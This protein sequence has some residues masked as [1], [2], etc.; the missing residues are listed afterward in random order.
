ML[1][2]VKQEKLKTLLINLG[3]SDIARLSQAIELGRRGA[4]VDLPADEI[5]NLLRPA[6]GDVKTPHLPTISRVLCEPFEDFFIPEKADVKR[7]GQMPRDMIA[8]FVET[9]RTLLGDAAQERE[10]AMIALFSRQDN[11]GLRAAKLALWQECGGVW[12]DHLNQTPDQDLRLA[13]GGADG[14]AAV[15][16]AVR[17]IQ[18]A[19]A[20]LRL[21][22]ALPRRPAAT[23]PPTRIE[24]I[25]KLLRRANDDALHGDGII[26]WALFRRLRDGADILQVFKHMDA[27]EGTWHDAMISA[28]RA[29]EEAL[30]TENDAR[31]EHLIRAIKQGKIPAIDIFDEFERYLNDATRAREA[32]HPEN[33][34]T[35]KSLSQRRIKT[36]SSLIETRLI[37]N[38]NSSVE[39][40]MS[41]LATLICEGKD[42][43]EDLAATLRKSEYAATAL[44]RSRDLVEKIGAR[45]VFERE[46][47]ALETTLRRTEDRL[48]NWID[49][50]RD[51]HP[52]RTR[53]YILY[54]VRVVE[55]ILGSRQAQTAGD[56]LLK[57]LA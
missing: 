52:P 48:K 30:L 34:E 9:S 57:A 24:A 53:E 26:L 17:S 36:L 35:A 16:E 45:A 37:G 55:M 27:L 38:V 56:R 20:V 23:P 39:A 43:P 50:T 19:P 29:I 15:E 47:R 32:C 10:D 4:G 49:R 46:S 1:C 44:A 25:A 40:A 22:G 51:G 11:D 2:E 13:Y 21:R 42:A 6:L 18:A 7:T 8:A 54:F 33:R 41:S 14:V 28:R 5:L 12:W 3:D 31:A